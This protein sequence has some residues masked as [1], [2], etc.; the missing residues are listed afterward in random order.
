[1]RERRATWVLGAI[2]VSL[3]ALGGWKWSTRRA[4][5]RRVCVFLEAMKSGDTK[6]LIEQ[7][8]GPALEAFLSQSPEEQKTFA[9]SI[10]GAVSEIREVRFEN[11]L[12]HVRVLWKV[13]GFD[14]WSDLELAKAGGDWKIIGLHQPKMNPTWEQVRKRMAED[15]PQTS[16]HEALSEKLQHRPGVEVRPLTEAELNR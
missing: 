12:A 15:A 10:P 9:A 5:E 7:L 1:M 14:V 11:G 13:S 16:S 2:V 6:T 8:N 3:F 4:V